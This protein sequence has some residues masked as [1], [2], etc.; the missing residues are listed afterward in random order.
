M[1]IKNDFEVAQSVEKVWR[2]SAASRETKTTASGLS[3]FTC[4]IGAC[5]ALAMSVQ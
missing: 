4:Q 1:L 5:T 3:P 2:N